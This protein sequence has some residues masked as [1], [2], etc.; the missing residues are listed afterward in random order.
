VRHEPGA[1]VDRFRVSLA[2]KDAGASQ[3]LSEHADV[4]I[5]RPAMVGRP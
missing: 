1:V 3:A 2:W 5:V 4:V